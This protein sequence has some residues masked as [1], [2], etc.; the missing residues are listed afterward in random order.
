MRLY[1]VQEARKANA[2]S[3]IGPL[4]FNSPKPYSTTTSTRRLRGRWRGSLL[5]ATGRVPP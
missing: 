2:N 1:T 4:A 5:L 3:F